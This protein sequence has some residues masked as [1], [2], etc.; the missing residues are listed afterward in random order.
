MGNV[1]LKA[2]VDFDG[3]Q[4]G[5]GTLKRYYNIDEMFQVILQHRRHV[6]GGTVLQ[7]RQYVY[8]S[9]LAHVGLKAA[10]TADSLALECMQEADHQ[11]V[12]L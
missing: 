11:E 7:H 2:E 5:T 8:V 6:S 12:F 9:V 4:I 3:R 1:R 10:A